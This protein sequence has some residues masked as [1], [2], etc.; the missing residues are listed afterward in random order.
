M[1]DILSRRRL[2]RGAAGASLASL[3]PG[4]AGAQPTESDAP[5]QV[6]PEA[7][8]RELG[9]EL[10]TPP[11]PVATYVGTRIVGNTLYVAGH[12]PR[13][14]HALDS[15]RNRRRR[16]WPT[17]SAPWSPESPWQIAPPQG[18]LDAPCTPATQA[19]SRPP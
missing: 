3:V 5:W 16:L 8:L 18:H 9:I 1:F 4:I 14:A 13:M 15:Q 7:R 2:I 12:T 11:P 19:A 17:G 6:S 10:H